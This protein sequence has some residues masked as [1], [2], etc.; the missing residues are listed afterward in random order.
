VS[1]IVAFVFL[2]F[3]ASIVAVI[4][5]HISLSQIK[6]TGDSGHGMALAGTILGWVGIALGI[7]FI[8]LLAVF[9]PW[10]ISNAPYY[11]RVNM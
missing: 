4:T 1:G 5:G 9:L 6:R 11:P 7:L 8:V 3:I 10:F 2:P